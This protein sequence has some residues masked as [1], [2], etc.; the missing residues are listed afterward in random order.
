M[1]TATRTSGDGWTLWLAEYVSDDE[2]V[3]SPMRGAFLNGGKFAR[4]LEEECRKRAQA[5]AALDT[6][7]ERVA[8]LSA[9]LQSQGLLHPIPPNPREEAAEVVVARVVGAAIARGVA[10]AERE[11]AVEGMVAGKVAG[12]DRDLSRLR[13]KM[14]YWERMNAEMANQ[15][16]ESIGENAGVGRHTC[17]L[18]HN[19]HTYL[20]R[21]LSCR[22]VKV[23]A[24]TEG[25]AAEG[26]AGCVGRSLRDW[27]VCRSHFCSGRLGPLSSSSRAPR[28]C[29]RC[30]G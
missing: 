26:I 16:Q 29:S 18:P 3:R 8:A 15:S 21:F 22:D 24:Q 27:L 30:R 13:D 25:E 19:F 12:K 5:E 7:R 14:Q 6:E 20:C 17:G 10:L 9:L 23:A 4:R 2:S 1:V 11:E 28:L